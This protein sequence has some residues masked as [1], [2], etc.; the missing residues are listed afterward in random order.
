MYFY[1]LINIFQIWNSKEVNQ[2]SK[3]F[4]WKSLRIY[5]AL[6]VQYVFQSPILTM[7]LSTKIV[8]IFSVR[9]AFQILKKMNALYANIH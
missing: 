7:P 9:I 4:F 2:E 8:E 6:N 5:A 1:S 3:I